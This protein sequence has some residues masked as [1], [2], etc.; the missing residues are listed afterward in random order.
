MNLKNGKSVGTGPYNP[1]ES[2]Y[3]K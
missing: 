3:L 2:A 1:K